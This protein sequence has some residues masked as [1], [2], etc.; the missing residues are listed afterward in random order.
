[1]YLR[2]TTPRDRPVPPPAP[3]DPGRGQVPRRA[4]GPERSTGPTRCV[5]A[6]WMARRFACSASRADETCRTTRSFAGRWTEYV[7]GRWFVRPEPQSTD[8]TDEDVGV[9][10]SVPPAKTG[11]TD[12]DVED[13]VRRSVPPPSTGRTDVDVEETYDWIGGDAAKYKNGGTARWE[14][15]RTSPHGGSFLSSGILGNGG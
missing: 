10:W 9:R 7:G 12:V 6:T 1:M 15:G 2:D 4:A 5:L 8:R 11:R 3:I 14:V 13:G